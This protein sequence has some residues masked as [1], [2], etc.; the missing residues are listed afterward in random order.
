[1]AR[2]RRVNFGPFLV[3][4]R[5]A[6][7]GGGGRSDLK[8]MIGEI[9]RDKEG[10]KSHTFKMTTLPEWQIAAGMTVEK[11]HVAAVM[12]SLEE[13]DTDCLQ[14]VNLKPSQ[15]TRRCCVLWRQ[16]INR[17]A[18]IQTTFAWHH[19]LL[20]KPSD[21]Q[22]VFEILLCRR[23]PPCEIEGFRFHAIS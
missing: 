15:M 21:K 19:K 11:A 1:M 20:S 17:K 2:R 3:N 8:R 16:G 23:Q 14:L 7:G 10:K 5:S 9:G 12:K 4:I 13:P 6:G 18:E 22:P